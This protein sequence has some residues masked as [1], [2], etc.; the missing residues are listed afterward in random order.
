VAVSDAVTLFRDIAGD[1][2]AKAATSIKPDEQQLAQIDQPAEDNVWHEKPNLSRDQVK[3]QFKQQIDKFKPAVGFTTISVTNGWHTDGAQSKKDANDA[4]DAATNA[5][6]GDRQ[7]APISEIDT[8]AGGAAASSQLQQAASDN[9]PEETKTAANEY[10]RRTKEFLSSKM[11]P[12]RRDQ[13]IWRLKKMVVECQGH[14]DC[15]KIWPR[16]RGT[17]PLTLL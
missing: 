1:A 2:A 4:A 15:K 3:E 13:L 10:S 14:S 17:G 12:E 5:A 16:T 7:N 9:V 6:L 8:R 11:P